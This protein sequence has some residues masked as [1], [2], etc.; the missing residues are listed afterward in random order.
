MKL[1]KKQRAELKMKF[2]GNCAYCGVDLSDKWH[3]DH[4]KPILR[5]WCPE[6]WDKGDDEIHNLFP[7]CVSCNISKMTFDIEEW[8]EFLMTK[9]EKLNRYEKNFRLAVAFGQI[10]ITPKP[11]IFYFEKIK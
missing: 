6:K 8:R 7:A 4:V 11:I 5:G 9:V 3:A 2:G 1:S 10:E